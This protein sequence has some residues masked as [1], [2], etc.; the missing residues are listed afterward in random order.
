MIFFRAQ[1]HGV[2]F[3][4]VSDTEDGF[5]LTSPLLSCWVAFL[6][7]TAWLPWHVFCVVLSFLVLY[8]LS[9]LQNVVFG[10]DRGSMSW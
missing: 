8:P 3:Q 6:A 10:A 2:S 1:H 4:Y 9:I 7:S 5:L